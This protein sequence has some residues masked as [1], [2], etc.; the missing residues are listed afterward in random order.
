[1]SCQIIN[2][3]ELYRIRSL[4]ITGTSL[5]ATDLQDLPNLRH[6]E[7]SINGKIEKGSFAHLTS[8]RSLDI[9]YLPGRPPHLIPGTFAG[10]NS[11]QA[12]NITVAPRAQFT[13]DRQTLT[14]LPRLKDLSVGSIAAVSTNALDDLHSL[15]TVSLTSPDAHEYDQPA[16]PERLLHPNLALERATFTNF[17]PPAHLNL[18]SPKAACYAIGSEAYP[19]WLLP[20]TQITV[21][22]ESAELLEWSITSDTTHTCKIIIG[23]SRIVVVPIPVS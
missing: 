10:L 4:T 22:G 14:G 23:A 18:G 11:L 15:I 16:V 21:S 5:L 8:L 7:I 19:G 2:P 17:Q 1:M 6:L 3:G 9:N 13:L 12:L 20:D